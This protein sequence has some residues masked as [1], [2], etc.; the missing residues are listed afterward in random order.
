M[1]IS[2]KQYLLE[3]LCCGNCAAKIQNDIRLLNGIKSAEVNAD[4]GIL[5]LELD[6][7]IETLVNDITNIAVSH[8]EDIVVKEI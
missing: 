6:T 8:D 1:A 2:K 3:G 5:S 4:T 7:D